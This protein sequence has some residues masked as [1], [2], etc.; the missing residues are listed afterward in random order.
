[1]D[2]IEVGK[3]SQGKLSDPGNP[4]A[5]WGIMWKQEERHFWLGNNI[6]EG[7][8]AWRPASGPGT[9]KEAVQQFWNSEQNDK[10]GRACL[11]W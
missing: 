6:D 1:M 10:W 8:E 9:C 4:L 7:P 5:I 2:G 3:E 11:Y